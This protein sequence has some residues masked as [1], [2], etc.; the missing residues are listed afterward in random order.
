MESNTYEVLQKAALFQDIAPAQCRQLLDCLA[1]RVRH[2]A[3][4]EI[5]HLA[6]D[7]VRHIGIVL[8][9]TAN[10]YLEHADG[11]HTLMAT[12]GPLSMF[13]EV[14]VSARTH[15]S[16]V[17]VCAA[18]EVAAV[19]IEYERIFSSAAAACEGH[20]TLLQNMLK[21]IGGKYFRLFDRI[22]ILREKTL[23]GRIMAY[24]Y[25]LGGGAAVRVTLPFTKTMLAEY[26]LANRSALSKELRKMEDDGLIKVNARD[27]EIYSP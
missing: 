11:S 17:T 1:P 22:N 9:G 24:L 14:L 8:T 2:F 25:A 10:A 6:G 16:P 13:G 15:K 18:S 23:R 4:N 21:V 3:K 19:F 27:I 20:C 5:I 7:Y 26:L 12:H